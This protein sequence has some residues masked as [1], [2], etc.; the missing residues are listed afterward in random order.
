MACLLRR[1]SNHRPGRWP[2][3]VAS[4]AWCWTMTPCAGSSRRGHCSSVHADRSSAVAA[5][6]AITLSGQHV[7]LAPCDHHTVFVKP[8][9]YAVYVD[10][11]LSDTREYVNSLNNHVDQR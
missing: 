1:R 6:E 9:S 2:R 10:E 7:D 4:G 5:A 8:H 3:I 11:R